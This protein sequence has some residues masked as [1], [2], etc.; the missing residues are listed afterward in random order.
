MVAGLGTIL[1]DPS[2]GDMALYF[3]S[4]ERLLARPA[5]TLLPAHGPAIPDGHG[6]L[7]EYLAHRKMREARVL[8]SLTSEAASVGALVATAYSD[9][10]KA[11]WP[12]AER[13]L[14]AHLA[15]LEREGLAQKLG[16][17]WSR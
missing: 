2:E 11:L 8:G 16:D 7:R 15:K 3:G 5:M 9:T 12:L 4:L 13:S 10:P 14:L 1:I 17:R 6:K